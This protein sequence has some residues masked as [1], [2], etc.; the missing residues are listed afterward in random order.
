MA[1][2]LMDENATREVKDSELPIPDGDPNTVYVIRSITKAK[3]RQVIKRHTRPVPDK[4][5]RRMVDQ[6]DAQAV[7]DDLF[8]YALADWR[9]VTLH[10]QPVPCTP[11]HKALLDSVRTSAILDAAGIGAV[12]EAAAQRKESFR[13]PANVA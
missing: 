5:S 13:E 2:Q 11:E 3:Y 7:S 8:D 10:G 12:E 9:G 4:Q 6:T 1:V